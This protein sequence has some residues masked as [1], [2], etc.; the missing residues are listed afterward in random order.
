MTLFSLGC[1]PNDITAPDQF[2]FGGD[3]PVWL[4]VPSYYDHGIPTPLLFVLHGYGANGYTQKTYTCYDLLP[5]RCSG[6]IRQ[7]GIVRKHV[8]SQLYTGFEH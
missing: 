7:R 6:E 5:Q 2:E 1:L 3:R 4:D 8:Q